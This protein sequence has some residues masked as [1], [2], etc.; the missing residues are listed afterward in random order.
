[1]NAYHIMIQVC[2]STPI[3]WR[4]IEVSEQLSFQQLHEAMLVLFHW[5]EDRKA[6][7]QI[8][9]RTLPM[10]GEKN[11]IN[12]LPLS[13]YLQDATPFTYV[14]GNEDEE[15]WEISL[16]ANKAR[17]E[18]SG[19]KLL[20]YDQEYP[21]YGMGGVT[22][23]QNI[24]K[25][26]ANIHPT[27][28]LQF[29]M[30]RLTHPFDE[31]EIAIYFENILMQNT[32]LTQNLHKAE[33]NYE[34]QQCRAQLEQSHAIAP[35][36]ILIKSS[37]Q[38]YPCYIDFLDDGIEIMVFY[39][40]NGFVRSI[41]N[42]ISEDPDLLFT[43]ALTIDFLHEDSDATELYLYDK[44]NLCYV[45][46]AGCLPSYPKDKDI[47]LLTT[48][49]KQ[50]NHVIL[51]QK[52]PSLSKHKMLVIQDEIIKE[53]PYEISEELC[54]VQ[55]SH[56]ERD[57]LLKLPH[58]NECIAMNFTAVP[59]KRCEETKNLDIHLVARGNRYVK[60]ELMNVESMTMLIEQ[61]Y[62][63]LDELIHDRCIPES[64]STN[65]INLAHILQ[66]YCDD[67]QIELQLFSPSS[68]YKE[69]LLEVLAN[70]L[71]LTSE[72]L[73]LMD[74]FEKDIDTNQIVYNEHLSLPT[75]MMNTKY[76]N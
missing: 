8:A 35:H 9:N 11:H 6:Y 49:L 46:K 52:L 17:R 47:V 5:K 73:L 63:F 14:Y 3:I 19:L 56:E 26:V 32:E 59:G 51:T 25:E 41:I 72:E 70:T 31:Q 12:C 74:E 24:K 2:N 62:H 61:L 18:H 42:S 54:T 53:C 44:Q 45:Y 38:T 48:I 39:D 65:S 10:Y 7:F 29:L 20:D 16:F 1:M 40:Q 22:L 33:L 68:Q 23:Y 64:I 67:L 55:L 21:I 66:P 34:L 27:S 4:K 76:Y 36:L 60:D 37:G 28:S 75:P 69:D 58:T 50:L 43:N 15:L 71:N 57:T 30:K 13:T